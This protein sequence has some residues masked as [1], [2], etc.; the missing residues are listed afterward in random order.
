[1][2]RSSSTF[3]ALASA[4]ALFASIG[5]AT[6]QLSLDVLQR[7]GYGVVPISRPLPNSLIVRAKINGRNANLVVDTGVAADGI[8]L[9]SDYAGAVR[10]T[11]NSAP[12]QGWSATGRALSVR[13]A[14]AD[15]VTLGN[16]NLK[17]VPVYLGAFQG[18]R[19]H[20]V[21]YRI[22]ADGFIGTGFLRTCSAVID[23]HD[24]RLYIRPPG[25]GR[26]AVLGPALTA[27]GFAAVPFVVA[28]N[29]ALVETQVNGVRAAMEIDTGATGSLIDPGFA[30]TAKA[31][32]Y[33]TGLGI[34]DAAGVQAELEQSRVRSFT[35]G[36]VP[37]LHATHVG[38]TPFAG[39][40]ATHGKLVG[41]LGMDIL[42]PNGTIIDYGEQ[43]LYFFRA[44]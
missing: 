9:D 4:T 13:R 28:S 32:G 14:V 15:L 12:E 19:A 8:T 42:G 2:R 27:I 7:D 41:L 26:R 37:P 40:S 5:S 25:Q 20:D 23:L 29:T 36:G 38:V 31:H 35:I 3:V 43:K 16:A 17:G 34:I 39:Y 24:L 6:A 18:L 21:R 33:K 11:G 44:R 10:L 30:A 1:M 22:G